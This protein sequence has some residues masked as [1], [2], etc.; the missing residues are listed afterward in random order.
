[1]KINYNTFDNL[2]YNRLALKNYK[3]YKSA[4]PCSHIRFKNFLEKNFAY[5]LFKKFSK[6]RGRLLD[7]SQKIWKKY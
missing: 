4:K 7:K 6:I 3:N 2:K 1:M 5:K